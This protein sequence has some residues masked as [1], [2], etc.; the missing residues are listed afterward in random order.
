MAVRRIG[1]S[2]ISRGLMTIKMTLMKC[3]TVLKVSGGEMEP[4]K[5]TAI[6]WPETRCDIL[7]EQLEAARRRLKWAEQHNRPWE[8]LSE[9]ALL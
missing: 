5:Y 7:R 4:V 2:A 3:F 8:E 6:M 9:K 1:V